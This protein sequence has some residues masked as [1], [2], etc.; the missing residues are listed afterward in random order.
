MWRVRLCKQSAVIEDV[1][2]VQIG[3]AAW[4]AST[5]TD[6]SLAALHAYL[7]AGGN[8]I[9]T[10]NVVRRLAKKPQWEHLSTFK[11]VSCSMATA[12]QKS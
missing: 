6:D 3:G 10:A 7:D 9:D 5:N 12:P 11:Y 8:L 1:L 2:R 4:S